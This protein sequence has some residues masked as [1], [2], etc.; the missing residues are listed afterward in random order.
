MTWD[1]TGMGAV[2]C[3]GTTPSEIFDALCAG[4]D[5]R[6][7]LQVFDHEKYRARNAYE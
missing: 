1:I 3:N 2:A 7:P 4:R 6:G 5:G